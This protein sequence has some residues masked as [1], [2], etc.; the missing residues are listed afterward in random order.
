[1]ISAII[2]TYNREKFLIELFASIEKQ[3]IDPNRFE[4]VIVDNNSTDGTKELSKHFA[5]NNPHLNVR[6]LFEPNQ[7]L[8]FARNKGVAESKGKWVTFLDDDAT[9]TPSFLEIVLD[10]F[11]KQPNVA[12]IGGK[13]LLDYETNPPPNWVSKYIVGMFGYFNP[14]NR[15]FVFRKNSFPR[16]SNMSFCKSVFDTVGGFN[17]KLGRSGGNMVGS[18]EKE[19]FA[20]FLANGFSATYLPQAVVYHAVPDER[21][22]IKNVLKHARGIGYSEAIM[23]KN[24]GILGQVALWLFETYKWLAS[25]GLLLGYSFLLKVR[26]GLFLLRFRYNVTAGMLGRL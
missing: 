20:R 15:E 18:E 26:K 24:K 22:E 8:S 21:L 17:T 19:F 9:L 2:C 1:M 5:K 25:I 6:Y 23:A 10:Y 3:T 11:E 7:G 14:S 12:C 16:G 4:V 13:I